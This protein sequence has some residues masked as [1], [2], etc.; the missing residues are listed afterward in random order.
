M[1]P[2]QPHFEQ[3]ILLAEPA[4]ATDSAVVVLPAHANKSVARLPILADTSAEIADLAREVE[5][6]L[7]VADEN[8]AALTERYLT[9]GRRL[10]AIS[11][12]T[13]HGEFG[14]LLAREF[15]HRERSTLCEY[16]T[17]AKWFD[18]AGPEEKIQLTGLFKHGWGAVLQEIRRQKNLKRARIAEP[19]GPA[20]DGNAL[21]ILHGDCLVRLRELP[22]DSTD[23]VITSIPYFHR[24][25]FPVPPSLFGGRAD[26]SHEWQTHKIAQREFG[27]GRKVMTDSDTCQH[28]GARRVQL[29]WE[30]TVEEY[31]SDIVTV[32]KEI[33]RV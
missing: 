20:L 28:C 21:K 8:Q 30:D 3:S 23:C 11:A 2:D 10:R 24:L 19:I 13:P 5:E 4:T 15:P 12:R 31:V 7:G 22:D 32:C 26:C 25:P 1:K 9:A 16:M 29:G 6:I 18:A 17:L 14:P 27:T 33:K